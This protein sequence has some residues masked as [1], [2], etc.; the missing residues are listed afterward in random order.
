ME[1]HTLISKF[2]VT[3]NNDLGNNINIFTLD[4]ISLHLFIRLVVTYTTIKNLKAFLKLP[5]FPQL[6]IMCII[7]HVNM[8]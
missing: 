1:N 2:V 7:F 8:K 4:T 6:I 5:F 3:A